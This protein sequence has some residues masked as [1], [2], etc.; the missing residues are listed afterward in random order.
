M[1]VFGHFS[2]SRSGDFLLALTAERII[3]LERTK[4]TAISWS[5]G[6][7]KGITYKKNNIIY[8]QGVLTLS[9]EVIAFKTQLGSIYGTE[10]KPNAN[11][12]PALINSRIISLYSS[13]YSIISRNDIAAEEEI[14][15]NAVYPL[16]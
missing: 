12:F 3:P 11:L 8:I 5:V 10:L 4:T 2:L 13:G 16:I 6:T 7:F 14:F 9:S 1:S 15:I